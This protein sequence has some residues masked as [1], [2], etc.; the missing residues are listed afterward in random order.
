MI[1]VKHNQSL[2][3]ISIKAFGSVAFVFDL[4][5]HNGLSITSVLEPGQEIEIPELETKDQDIVDYYNENGIEPAT[6][7]TADQLPPEG[8]CNYCKLFE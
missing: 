7:I 4:A 1:I 3:D 8:D 5:L 2:F 6:T